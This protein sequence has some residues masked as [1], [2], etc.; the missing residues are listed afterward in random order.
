MTQLYSAVD[1]RTAPHDLPCRRVADAQQSGAIPTFPYFN[2]ARWI[3]SY[4]I[5][6]N[7]KAYG[8]G[9]YC[10]TLTVKSPPGCTSYCCTK[11]DVKKIEFNVR[12]E[13]NVLGAVIKSTVNGAPTR[14]GPAFEYPPAGPPGSAILRLT[15]LGLGPGD[16]GAQVCLTLAANALGRG[17][18][19]LEELCVPPPG[20]PGSTCS[21]ALFDSQ[22]DCCPISTV[23]APIPQTPPLLAGR[24]G[25]FP[26]TI[27][28]PPPPPL[29]PPATPTPCTVCAYLTLTPSSPIYPISITTEQCDNFAEIITAD[30]SSQ[31]EMVAAPL[32]DMPYTTSCSE[33]QIKVCG[34]FKSAVETASLQTWVT[35][36]VAHWLSLATGDSSSGSGGSCP[37]F[38]YGYRVTVTVGGDGQWP[39]IPASCLSASVSTVCEAQPVPYPKCACNSRPRATPFAAIPLIFKAPGR[40]S[41]TTLYCFTTDVISPYSSTGSCGSSTTL[42]KA[43]IWANEAKRRKVV[44]IA[45]QPA[46]STDLTFHAPTW[47]AVGEQ[48]LKATPLMWDLTQAN[49]GKICLELDKA[50]DLGSFCNNVPGSPPTCWITFFSPDKKCCPLFAASLM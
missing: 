27:Y 38:L 16:D 39:T 5:S 33:T 40:T 34:T 45:V 29:P 2:C 4:R 12:R 26:P 44:A 41:S 42:L 31:A 21:V 48:T 20:R 11:S 46:N 15:Q 8:G 28:P 43:E 47:G 14:I 30:V 1:F 23:S 19:T 10:F 17:C 9:T 32:L 50:T 24:D 35:S 25:P 22:L 3:S 13:C 7:F 49:G 18:S 6:P 36:R 37:A